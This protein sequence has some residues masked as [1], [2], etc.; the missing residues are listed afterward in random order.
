G[1]GIKKSKQLEI[2]ERFKQLNYE[3]NAKYGGTGLGLT[4]CKGILT[5]LGGDI[6][7]SSEEHKGTLFEFTIPVK[8][9]ESSAEPTQAT[10]PKEKNFLKGKM[11]LIAEDDS[12]IRLLFKIVLKDTEANVLFAKTGWEAVEIY[13][14]TEQIDVVLLDIRMPTM[15][16]IE[17]MGKILNINP[18]AKIIMQTAYSMPDEKERCYQKGCL[19]FLSKPIIKDELYATLYKWVNTEV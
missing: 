7:V 3:S 12:L 6:T 4:I 18:K 14:E 10:L 13:R 11:I 16:G 2:F 19:G 5:L 15:S 17:A 1:M 9:A 8:Y